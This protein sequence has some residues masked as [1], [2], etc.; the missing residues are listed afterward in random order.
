MTGLDTPGTGHTF[1][2]DADEPAY[3]R[4]LTLALLGAVFAVHFLD[5]QLLAILIPPIKA[6][7]ALSDT[8]LGLL[9][10]FVLTVMLSTVGLVIA[11]LAD[12]S[13]RARIITWSLALF[14]AMTALCGLATGFWQLLAARVGVG[15]GEGGTN[16]ASHSLIADLFPT[17]QRAAAMAA[18]CIGPHAGLVLAFGLGGWL[19]Q[20]VGWR[21]TFI[22]VGALGLVLA[23]VTRVGLRDPRPRGWSREATPVPW[24]VVVGSMLRSRVLRHLVA[25]GTLAT[26]AALG[27]VTWL[28]ALLTRAHGFTLAASGLALAL[29]FGLGGAIGT[30]LFGRWSD[31]A[32]RARPAR[33]PGLLAGCQLLLAL[34]WAVALLIQDPLVA[35]V[36]LLVPCLLTGA[37]IGPTLALVQDAVDPRTRAFSAAVLLLVVNL[38]GGGSGP[39]AVGV[40]SD[41][42]RDA[43]GAQSLRYG[44]LAMPL[45]LAWSAYHYARVAAA[46]TGESRA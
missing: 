28:P 44:L 23:L 39:L 6:E 42:L 13:D 20:T 8:A 1:A 43:F 4:R 2:S 11:R 10:G 5:R 31:A 25:G 41:A 12:R 9:S 34:L 21:A 16:P 45:L 26:A 29:A 36:A 24:A 19:G 15:I 32:G 18:Y 37:Y 38:V 35:M 27:L 17:H 3:Q 30:Y 7:L 33:K 14:S 22:I 40:A 46:L